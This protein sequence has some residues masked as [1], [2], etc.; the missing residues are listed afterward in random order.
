MLVINYYTV[1]MQYWAMSHFLELLVNGSKTKSTLIFV[2]TSSTLSAIFPR[3]ALSNRDQI[4]SISKVIILNNDQHQHQKTIPT[5]SNINSKI[6]W[7]LT[8]FVDYCS[9]EVLFEKVCVC[10]L[11]VCLAF[12]KTSQ[13]LAGY[14]W[15]GYW[16]QVKTIAGKSGNR[17][18]W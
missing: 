7:Y 5:N 6:N 9:R 14:L 15:G 16:Q 1:W 10:W 8:P 4:Y 12:S 17:W 13:N 3:H 11:Q 18:E 2:E